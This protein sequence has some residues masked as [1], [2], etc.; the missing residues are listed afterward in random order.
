MRRALVILLIIGAVVG[1]GRLGYQQY[2]NAKA[3]VTPD[4]EVLSVFTRRYHLPCRRVRQVLPERQTILTVPNRR[5]DHR[6]AGSGRRSSGG[7][8][9]VGAARYEGPRA[10]AAPGADR[11]APGQAQLA[12]LK[13]GPNAVDVAPKRR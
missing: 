11:R 7:R 10:G 13:T 9:G 4:Y 8:A 6:R 1:L 5:H 12:Q 3:A 2:G